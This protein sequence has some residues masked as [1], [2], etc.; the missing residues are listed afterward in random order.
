MFAEKLK[1]VKHAI[2]Q[3]L[4]ILLILLAVA[5]AVIYFTNRPLFWTIVNGVNVFSRDVDEGTKET[6]KRLEE[7]RKQFK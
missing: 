3:V 5:T 6:Q 2:F 4:Q 7:K 1:D